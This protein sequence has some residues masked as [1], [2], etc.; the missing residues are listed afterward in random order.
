MSPEP[1]AVSQKDAG[2]T[3]MDAYLTPTKDEIQVQLIGFSAG[4]KLD[5]CEKPV[6]WKKPCLNPPLVITVNGRRS[7]RHDIPPSPKSEKVKLVG[8]LSHSDHHW[9]TNGIETMNDNYGETS[10][11]ISKDSLCDKERQERLAQ[12]M[13]ET[14]EWFSRVRK[15]SHNWHSEMPSGN[16]FYNAKGLFEETRKKCSVDNSDLFS[17]FVRKN[18]EKFQNLL[19]ENSMASAFSNFTQKATSMCFDNTTLGAD[20]DQLTTAE[21]KEAFSQARSFSASN[22]SFVNFRTTA[23]S[24]GLSSMNSNQI[25]GSSSQPLTSQFQHVTNNACSFTT[26]YSAFCH[27]RQEFKKSVSNSSF[28]TVCSSKTGAYNPSKGS[29]TDLR[30]PPFSSFPSLQTVSPVAFSLASPTNI[31]F[32]TTTSGAYHMTSSRNT[33]EYCGD[34]NTYRFS[35]E[36]VIQRYEQGYDS[37]SESED[38]EES[39]D[40][41]ISTAGEPSEYDDNSIQ[42]V[43]IPSMSGCVLPLECGIKRENMEKMQQNIHRIAMELMTTERTY[44]SILHLLDQVF[45]FRVDQENRVHSMFP[46][47]VVTQMFSNLKSLYKLHHDF[48]LPQLEERLENWE[49]KSKIGDI[50]K[51]FAPFLKMYTEFVK[52]YDNSMNLINLWYNKHPHFAQIMDDIHKMEECGNLTLQHHLLTPVQR[53]PRYQLLLKDYLK[54]LPDDSADRVDTEKAL[55]LVS[56]AATHANEAMKKIDKFKKLLEVQEMISGV[57]DLVSPT[58]EL[59]KEGKIIKISARSGDHQERHLFL[60]N[61]FLLLCSQRLISNRVV[62]GP[63]FRVRAKLGVEGLVIEEGDNLETANTFY[64]RSTGRSIELY[65]QTM[66]EKIAWMEA[67]A[68]AVHDLTQRKSSLKIGELS[69]PEGMELGT[70]APTFI[71]HDAISHCM[72]CSSQFNTFSLKRKHHCRAC[73]IVACNKCLSQKSAL[74]YDN[75]KV[76]RVCIQCH[77]ILSQN[78]QGKEEESQKENTESPIKRKGILEVKPSDLAVVSSYLHMRSRSR[79]WVQRWFSLHEDFVLYSFRSHEDEKALTS[80]PV[81]GYTVA[82]PDKTE[83]VDGRE[84][85]FKL[86]HKKKVY[87]FQAVDADEQKRWMSALEKASRA[88]FLSRQH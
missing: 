59:L 52:N 72:V 88:E 23:Q 35:T 81:P 46:Q 13:K 44:V 3:N 4:E 1:T 77:D 73:G 40:D 26:T 66:K 71:K 80:V 57:V 7:P 86:F 67:L 15:D 76:G 36:H 34:T 54:K 79:T 74:P 16:A 55:E 11:R 47:E 82:I 61:D 53:V 31:D 60:F 56:T 78:P 39:L 63:C 20:K 48:L 49:T 65:T 32:K 45:A 25:N 10:G 8:F 64:I 2:G 22:A 17:E 69:T 12:L 85:V 75:N 24:N 21:K 37:I 18:Q 28:S 68:K 38:D 9:N 14:R 70:R 41:V 5:K 19:Q 58:R 50:M 87:Y 84:N 33:F 83:N 30:N 29:K 42:D 43:D 51:N 6:N 62:S 27:Q